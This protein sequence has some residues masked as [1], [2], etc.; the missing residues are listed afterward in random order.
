MSVFVDTS[1]WFAAANDR[2]ASNAQARK[3]LESAGRLSTSTFILEETWRLISQRMSWSRAEAFWSGMRRG[4][5]NLEP[6]T[7]PDLDN[8]WLIGQRFPDQQF[9]LTD[10]TS[11]ALME[12][13]GLRQVASFDDDFLI[14]RYGRNNAQAFEVLR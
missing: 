6:V 8:A 4:I 10:R 9:S 11:F 3:I 14:Y 7:T 1:V 2:D 12:R 5:A 13:M